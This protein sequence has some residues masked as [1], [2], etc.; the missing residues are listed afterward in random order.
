MADGRKVVSEKKKAAAATK[1]LMVS[2]KQCWWLLASK[3]SP[4]LKVRSTTGVSRQ[5]S[6]LLGYEAML[7]K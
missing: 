1:K 5:A 6:C 4:V 2:G 3:Y 7:H